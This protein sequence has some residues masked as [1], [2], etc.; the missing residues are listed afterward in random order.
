[1]WACWGI[2]LLALR[3]GDLRRALPRFER[4]VG[5]CQDTE[6]PLWFPRVAAA[7]GAAYT[8][9]GRV[10]DAVPLL[11]QAIEQVTAT[12]LRVMQV[13]CHLSL[14]EAQVLAGR[15]EEAHARAERAPALTREHQ[16]RGHQAYAL[17]LLG[18]TAA[19]RE[20]PVSDQ[21]GGYYRQAVTLAEERG[22]EGVLII[23]TARSDGIW[24]RRKPPVAYYE[25]GRVE[26]PIALPAG[27]PL[28]AASGDEAPRVV[29]EV[30]F[31]RVL[32]PCW[33]RA[34]Y[35]AETVLGVV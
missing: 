4:A 7:L 9:T 29:R 30:L 13:L 17:R 32:A 15:L 28:H 25:G 2:G 6:L 18:E 12:E 8:L 11:T 23:L 33:S 14:G 27:L 5:L 35:V 20:P 24:L 26:I 34:T 10:P 3:Q 16:D 1:M 21:A 31:E 22:G 19:L